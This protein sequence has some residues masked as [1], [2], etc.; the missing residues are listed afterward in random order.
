MFLIPIVLN[1]QLL[2]RPTDV[3]AQAAY[4][5][6]GRSSAQTKMALFAILKLRRTM[7]ALFRF[8]GG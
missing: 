5:F 8:T 2:N 1:D 7:K 3:K 6:H 4:L